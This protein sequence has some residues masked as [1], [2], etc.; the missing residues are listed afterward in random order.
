MLLPWVLHCTHAYPLHAQDG[1]FSDRT[2]TQVYARG[3]K[4]MLGVL[5]IGRAVGSEG[6]SNQ[7][8]IFWSI[9][10]KEVPAFRRDG[11]PAVEAW[12]NRVSSLMPRLG[13]L[14]KAGVK[15]NSDLVH[16]TY[17]DVAMPRLATDRVVLLGD[18]AHA[19]S[20]QLGQGGTSVLRA[21]C[22]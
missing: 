13:P 20:P 18:A 8:T 2:L 17:V 7:V 12:R 5:P 15:E 4:D 22:N 3:A 1:E 11:Q 14:V 6:D 21:S 10:N 9:P 16:A 19:T